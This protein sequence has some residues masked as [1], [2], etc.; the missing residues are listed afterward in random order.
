MSEARAAHQLGNGPF[1]NAD[2]IRPCL[3][4]TRCQQSAWKTNI[5]LTPIGM[6]F[7]RSPNLFPPKGVLLMTMISMEQVAVPAAFPITCRESLGV[8]RSRRARH[9]D[10]ASHVRRPLT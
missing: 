5:L 9:Y 2:R 1:L 6:F 8:Q 10:R 7:I 3:P 4:D